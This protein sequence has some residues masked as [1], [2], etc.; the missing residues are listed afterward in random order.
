MSGKEGQSETIFSSTGR[1][2]PHR[3]QAN[4]LYIN[5]AYADDPSRFIGN[6]QRALSGD[7][8]LQSITRTVAKGVVSAEV[9]RGVIADPDLRRDLEVA[10]PLA[11]YG[12]NDSWLTYVSHNKPLRVS[13]YPTPTL[14]E[15]TSEQEEV[16]SRPPLE[17]VENVAGNGYIFTNSIKT[18]QLE[19]LHALWGDTFGWSTDQLANFKQRLEAENTIDA[20]AR[21]VWFCG[22]EEDGKLVSAAMAERIKLP[23]R[24]GKKLDCVESTE[25]RTHEKAERNGLMSAVVTVLTAQV[26]NDLGHPDNLFM[27]AECNVANGANVSG[28][29]AG[30]QVPQREIE[31]EGAR[32]TAPQVLHQNVG[33]NDGVSMEPGKYRDFVFMQLRPDTIDKYYNPT[34]VTQILQHLTK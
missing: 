27:F 10:V 4:R 30:F 19:D 33:I 7:E 6:Y 12:M 13:L 20:R 34:A 23:S 24:D 2:G 28:H 32:F 22:V 18:E 25:W 3:R 15:M 1:L 8:K 31:L 26:V 21:S 16:S 17:R 11:E 9:L 29:K 14:I 5:G